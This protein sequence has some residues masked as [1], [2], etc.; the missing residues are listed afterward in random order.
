MVSVPYVALGG[1]AAF[2]VISSLLV[3]ILPP[4]VDRPDCKEKSDKYVIKLDNPRAAAIEELPSENALPKEYQA[5]SNKKHS[6][7]SKRDTSKNVLERTKA[8]RESHSEL[9][10]RRSMSKIGSYPD[11]GICSE[12]I[13]PVPGV[14]YPWYES[15]LPTSIVPEN[16]NVELFVPAWTSPIYDGEIDITFTVKN[17][18]NFL[19][20]HSKLD[21][22][23]IE[24]NLGYLLLFV[25]SSFIALFYFL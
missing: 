24:G 10:S 9:F 14:R 17:S 13:S 20:L 18:T 8:F 5:D 6:R 25:L 12:I 1:Y 11:L 3:G 15:R 21:L 19:L 16:Y 23:F 4:L 2:V 7:I 22:P